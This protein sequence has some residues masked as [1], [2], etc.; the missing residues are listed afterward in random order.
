ML[1]CMSLPHLPETSVAPYATQPSLAVCD[2]AEAGSFSPR[3]D[4]AHVPVLTAFGDGRL[5]QCR[6][7]GDYD[8]ALAASKHAE[9]LFRS[10]HR[11][12]NDGTDGAWDELTFRLG[13]NTFVYVDLF[14]VLV[15]AD[16][17]A[18]AKE[19]ALS[20]HADCLQPPEPQ[21]GSY[22]L[23][24]VGREISTESVPLSPAT[25]ISEA[26]FHLHYG[27][28]AWQ[29]HHD[30]MTMLRDSKHGLSI[31]EGPPGTGKTSYLR[32]L[33][34]ELKDTHR[35]YFIPTGSLAVLSNPE[36]VG[37]W[38]NE[39]RRHEKLHFVVVLEDS[40]DV[41]MA[42]RSDNRDKVSAILNLTD[43]MLADFLRLQIICSVNCRVA[44]VDPALLRPGR[45]L[46][47]RVFDRL[48]FDDAKVLADSLGKTLPAEGAYTLAEVFADQPPAPLQKRPI[49]FTT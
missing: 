11:L 28:G 31:L 18:R 41:L 8:T 40:D 25:I 5:H 7:R 46:C 15:W 24:S 26:K 10:V 3:L 32:H 39:R 19:V 14:R 21:G 42:R 48:S 1:R 23:I 49:G 29:W 45:L 9:T 6:I 30:Y 12:K 17:A 16:T 44:E 22:D 43:G 47:H 20:F 27:Q 38:A 35:F 34:G 36:F 33:M 37:F 13:P 4:R 2:L